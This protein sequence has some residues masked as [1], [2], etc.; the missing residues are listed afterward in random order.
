M[1][2][3]FLIK[4]NVNILLGATK[5]QNNDKNHLTVAATLKRTF[6]I[7]VGKTYGD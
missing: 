7:T 3:F 4:L 2:V 6:T 5:E 1:F